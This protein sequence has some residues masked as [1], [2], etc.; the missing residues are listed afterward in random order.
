M[1]MTKGM[2]QRLALGAAAAL[3]AGSVNAQTATLATDAA[4]TTYNA[5]GS[6]MAKVITAG[7]KLRVIVRPFGGPDAYLDQLNN[8]ELNFAALSG[9]TAYLS[10]NGKNRAKKAYKNLRLLR[11]GAGGLKVGFIALKDSSITKVSDLRGKRVASDYGGH[12]VIGRSIAAALASAGLTWKDV[13]PVPVTGANDGV[14]A[15]DAGRVDACWASLGQPVIRQ[16]NAAKGVRYLSFVKTDQSLAMLRKMIFPGVKLE[17]VKKNPSIGVQD[18]IYMITYDA[19]M[20]TNKDVPD[21]VVGQALEGLWAKTDEL[22]KIH[23]GL[24]GFTHESAVTEIP[25]VPYHPAAIAFYKAKG[26]WTKEAEMA[27]NKF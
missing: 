19:Y 6:G 1:N 3:L 7:S 20:V 4:G 9:S 25:M 5:V 21:A 18:D 16:L 13:K 26:L 8:N 27:N 12:A 23:R 14:T 11:S 17:T 24:S 10:Y 15:L 22:V 2:W